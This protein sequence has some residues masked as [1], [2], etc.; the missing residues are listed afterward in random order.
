MPTTN[1]I[2]QRFGRLVVLAQLGRA[3]QVRCDCGTIKTVRNDHI[4][5]GGTKSCGCKS[6]D[7]LNAYRAEHKVTHGRSK[8]QVYRAW[9]S[10]IQRCHN[11][12]HPRYKDWGARGIYVCDRWRYSFANFLTDM[13]EPPP[14]TS[15]DRWPDNNGPYAPNNCRWATNIEQRHNRRP[16]SL[17]AT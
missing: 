4:R 9:T 8:T 15:L 6:V 12:R 14:G 17:S 11:P 13:G 2:G 7:H 3:S 16:I 1:L 10:A 5:D